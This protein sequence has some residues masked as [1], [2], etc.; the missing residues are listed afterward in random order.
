MQASES[1]EFKKPEKDQVFLMILRQFR[2]W[3]AK[4][5]IKHLFDDDNDISN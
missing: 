5:E 3:V 2:R 1:V 4:H